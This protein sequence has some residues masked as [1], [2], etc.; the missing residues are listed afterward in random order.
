MFKPCYLILL[1]VLACSSVSFAAEGDS[2]R[3]KRFKFYPLPAVGYS[4]ETRWYFGAVALANIRLSD[5]AADK[6]STVELEFNYTQ[7][8]Q[9]IYSENHELRFGNNTFLFTGENGFY[10][11]PEF[12]WSESDVDD[13]KISYNSDRLEI[14]NSFLTKIQKLP[15]LGIRYRYHYMKIISDT[16]TSG[17]YNPGTTFRSSGIGPSLIMDTRDN[18]MNASKGYYVFLSGLF[19]SKNR[20]ESD[21]TTFKRLEA[22][23]RAYFPYRNKSVLA[24]QAVLTGNWGERIPFRMQALMGGERIMRGYYY[25]RYRNEFLIATQAEYRIPLWKWFGIAGFH[26]HGIVF[27]DQGDTFIGVSYGG[28]IRIRL[29]KKDNINLRFDY[30]R[31][32]ASDGFYISF[33]EA[34]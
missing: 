21:V 12:Y 25:G 7:N 1:F 33:G 26:G 30:G 14:D 24:L 20:N 17:F 2:A 18:P 32:N 13:T 11:Y 10:R 19:F 15:F 34:F 22:D 8:K 5:F 27:G 23:I 28:G 6:M 9:F 3:V 31:G 16:D 4:P 29:D